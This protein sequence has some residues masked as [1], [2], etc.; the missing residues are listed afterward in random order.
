MAKTPR[1]RG[2]GGQFVPDAKPARQAPAQ[3]MEDPEEEEL[4]PAKADDELLDD[5]ELGAYDEND[6]EDADEELEAELESEPD[7]GEDNFVFDA[8]EEERISREQAMRDAAEWDVDIGDD[9]HRP[10]NL[11]APEPRFGFV[12][13]WVAATLMDSDF[14][15]N[16]ARQ[17]QMGWKPRPADTVKD[18]HRYPMVKDAEG[19]GYVAVRGLILMER[20]LKLHKKF[21]AAH[22]RRIAAMTSAADE[23]VNR[24]VQPGHP[25]SREARTNVTNRRPQVAEDAE[26][27]DS[28]F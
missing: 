27:G 21:Q 15:T 26:P 18:L 25:V 24:V 20:P 22:R 1:K 19:R 5:V 11:D 8:D 17:A 16:M 3:A 9:F 6:G 4:A 23:H 10:L 28:A 13:R 14:S 7:E 12:Q 2:P